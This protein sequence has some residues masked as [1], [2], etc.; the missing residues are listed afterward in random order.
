MVRLALRRSAALAAIGLG[1]H[2]RSGA[3]TV[4]CVRR[5]DAE[6]GSVLRGP[7]RRHILRRDVARALHAGGRY[8]PHERFDVLVPVEM[9]E[10]YASVTGEH[11]SAVATYSDF[12]RFETAGRVVGIK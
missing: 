7:V 1:G 12:R 10:E 5:R 11:I 3:A 2:C 9:R 6:A 8:E 4:R